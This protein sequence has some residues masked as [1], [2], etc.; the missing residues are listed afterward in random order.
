[1]E[2]TVKGLKEIIQTLNEIN[3][4]KDIS[5]EVTEDINNLVR[6]IKSDQFSGRPGLNVISGELRDSLKGIVNY[7][8]DGLESTIEGDEIINYHQFGTK[9]L[10]KRL[11]ID[12]DFE[13]FIEKDVVQTIE[14][15]ITDKFK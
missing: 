5:S 11:Y 6:D 15:Y 4:S 7:S 1:M 3:I 14:D 12:K 10:P 13:K 8:S 9:Y 2:L